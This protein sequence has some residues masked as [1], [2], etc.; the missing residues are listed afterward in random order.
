VFPRP[1]GVTR[2]NALSY[3]LRGSHN[4]KY[5][6][7]GD[8]NKSVI[9]TRTGLPSSSS[10]E[11]LRDGTVESPPQAD[12]ADQISY[13]EKHGANACNGMREEA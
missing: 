2:D 12:G 3:E 10:T 11:A 1:S 6:G 4:L 7:S 5:T 8:G 9:K 13:T